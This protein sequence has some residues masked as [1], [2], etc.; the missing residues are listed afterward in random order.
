M[1][2][3]TTAQCD[4]QPAPFETKSGVSAIQDPKAELRAKRIANL[5]P[6]QP[7]APSNN[8]R[9]RPKKDLDLAKLA[10]SHAE[11]A[12]K[13]LVDVMTAE[14]ATPSARVSAASELLDRGFGRAPQTLDVEHKVAFSEQFEGFMREVMGRRHAPMIEAEVMD[15][16]E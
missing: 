15:A 6:Q 9:G 12:I 16:A 4:V 8:P 13:T 1:D 11:T 2:I 10:Q 14:E 7:G 5:R 3:S